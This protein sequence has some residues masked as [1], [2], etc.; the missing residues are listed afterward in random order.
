M[1]DTK[2]RED[3]TTKYLE[4]CKSKPVSTI[5]QE[6]AIQLYPVLIQLIGYHNRQYYI[7]STPTISDSQYDMIFQYLKDMERTFPDIV[8]QDSP[9]QRLVYQLQTDFTQAHHKT[10]LLSLENSYNAHD[11]IARNDTLQK[12]VQKT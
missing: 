6:E 1:F 10:P 12:L 8:R 7:K 3:F 2:K 5:S 4:V 9:T 11:L